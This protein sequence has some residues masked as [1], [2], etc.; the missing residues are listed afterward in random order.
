MNINDRKTLSKTCS[1]IGFALFACAA[2]LYI[3]PYS[4]SFISATFRI[5]PLGATI[6]PIISSTG[7]IVS[8]FIV[9]VIYCKLSSSDIGKLVPVSRVRSGLLWPLM[10]ITLTV[11]FIS[12]YMTDI[13]LYNMSSI[14]IISKSFTDI[15]Y[16]SSYSIILQL[17]SVAVVPPLVEEFLFR[18]IILHKLLPYGSTFAIFVSSIL[19]ALLHGNIVQIPFAFVGALAMAFSVVKTH[20]L[21]PSIISHFLINLLSVALDAAE[22]YGIPISIQ[23]AVYFIWLFVIILGGILSAFI[24]SNNKYFLN[25]K[26]KKY[27]FRECMTACFSSVGI[28]FV[29]IFLILRTV[30]NIL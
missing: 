20:S 28:I 15:D 6:E 8:L 12:S 10:L 2:L 4:L 25:F 27:K 7:S 3:V 30:I 19:F 22:Y 21:L 23:N 17:I 5:N 1:G 9:G 14:G 29:S 11:S 26:V 13:M 24:L 18:G 16:G